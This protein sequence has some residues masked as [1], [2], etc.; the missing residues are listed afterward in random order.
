MLS[1]DLVPA[2]ARRLSTKARDTFALQQPRSF[3]QGST[4]QTQAGALP[5]FGGV[6][7]YG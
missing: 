3:A 1:P 6:D 4:R 7:L 5:E 2:D